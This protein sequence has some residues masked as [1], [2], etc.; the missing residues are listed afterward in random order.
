MSCTEYETLIESLLAE[1]IG[2]A[3]R[4]RLLAHSQECGACREFIDL[5]YQLRDPEIG[6]E[7]PTPGQFAAMRQN[8]LANIREQGASKP[9][10]AGIAEMLASLFRRP[11]FAMGAAACVLA[12]L[13]AG[14]FAGRSSGAT[15]LPP[16]VM[17]DSLVAQIGQE[18]EGNLRL[19]DVEDSPYLFSNVAFEESSDDR[20]AVRFDVTRHIEVRR[21]KDDPL[22][23]EILAQT[24]VNPTSVGTRLEALG[25][26]GMVMDPKIQEAL[27]FSMLNDPTLA[28]RIKAQNLLTAQEP[29]EEIQAAFMMV[30][31]GEENVSMRLRAMDYLAASGASRES[32]EDVLDNLQREADRPL[33]MRAVSFDDQP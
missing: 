28:V 8:V 30:L 26:A 2:D 5:H 10:V 17:M 15:V 14:Y 27:V 1:E 9:V 29:T 25:H 31:S 16:E 33:K 23:K 19:A 12:L 13:G 22:V 11:G 20:L 18:A 3:D 7:L 24:L 32:L 21:A 6:G 4:D